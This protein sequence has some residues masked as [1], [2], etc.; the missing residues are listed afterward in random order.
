METI[1]KGTKQT[2]EIASHKPTV[3]IGKR[4]SPVRRQRP[5]VDGTLDGHLDIAK[6]EALAQVAAGADAL[7]I[8]VDVPDVDQVV[9][10]PQIIETVQATVEVP[11]S[12][13]TPNLESLAAALDVYQGKPLVNGVNGEE[14]NLNRIL[15]LVAKHNA[16][17][18]GLCM[19]ENGI[20]DDPRRRLKIAS[21]IVERAE[22]VGIPRENILIDCLTMA[23]EVDHHAAMVTLETIRLVKDALGVNITLDISDISYDLPHTN[24]LH[25]TFLTAAIMAG[26]TAPQVSV[27]QARQ[28]VLAVDV[29]LGRDEHAMRYIKYFHFRRSGMRSMVDWELVG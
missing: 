21:K 10:L 2:V 3:L 12:L 27:S 20:P 16:A 14:E 7:N 18:V 15:P 9:L 17:V 28:N 19:D 23:V 5:L 24:A 6:N 29:L 26:V 22:A 25:Q 8:E 4:M 1:L 11:L 13:N